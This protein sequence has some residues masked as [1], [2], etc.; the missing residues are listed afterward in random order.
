MVRRHLA[1]TIAALCFAAAGAPIG[2]QSVDKVPPAAAPAGS[3]PALYVAARPGEITMFVNIIGMVQKPGRYEIS[4]ETDV[5]KLLALAGGPTT[6]ALLGSVRIA[7]AAGSD[8]GGRGTERTVD[9]RR[10]DRLTAADAALRPE[11]TVCVDA[12]AW[13]VFR[14]VVSLISVIAIVASAAAQ[15]LLASRR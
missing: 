3:P 11:D 14:D 9:L 10:L 15:I 1:A 2:A 4:R 5:V 7:H 13:V 12:S 6:N 8:S